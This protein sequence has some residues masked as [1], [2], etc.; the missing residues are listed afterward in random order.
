MRYAT[1]I[2]F[3]TKFPTVDDLIHRARKRI[4]GFAFEYLDGG[5]NEEV[6]KH[7]NTKALRAIELEPH[8][9]DSFNG[10]HLETELFGIN[11]SAPFGVAPLG[12]QGMIWPNASEILAKAAFRN[13]IPF[14]LSTVATSSIERISEITE[15]T[16]WF[17]LYHPADNSVKDDLIQRAA[18]AGCPVLVL[19]CDTPSYGFRPRE[20]R[21]GLSMP[22][23]MTS[24]N[25][26]QMLARPGWT[27]NTLRCGI[28]HFANLAPYMP[29]RLSLS[30]MAAF[31]NEVFDKRMNYDKIAAIRDQWP[32]KLILKGVASHK[33]AQ[34]AVDLGLDGIVVSN[35]GGR[36]LDAGEASIDSMLKLV[37]SF[38]SKT[39][40]MLDSGIRSGPDIAR[41]IA[42]G[43]SFTFLGR[44][45]MY[46]VAAL[47]NE[48]G[49][50]MT[51]L[52][53]AQLKQVMEQLGCEK[54]DQLPE[55][56]I[57]DRSI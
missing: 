22:P 12:L 10:A 2:N 29:K 25:L 33:D 24:S 49:E 11:Y 39:T 13:K 26:I 5:C 23:K 35:H 42:A 37:A 56:L 19:L 32:G 9:L 46:S 50:H 20:I 17:Q 21:V 45:F 57:S 51:G 28:P 8:Y 30:K 4:P 41:A 40:I 6:N 48:G 7:K 38:G 1:E 31:M 14:V 18:N 43:A 16:A 34:M 55:H 27:Y 15:G 36:Q 47:G 52:L 44:A 53:K 3:N 54:V